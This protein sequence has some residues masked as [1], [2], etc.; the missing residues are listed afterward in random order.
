MRR[1]LRSLVCLA[2]LFAGISSIHARSPN[3]TSGIGAL[4]LQSTTSD[5]N[6]IEDFFS[7]LAS[8]R[9]VGEYA[10]NTAFGKLTVAIAAMTPAQIAMGIPVIDRVLD[11]TVESADQPEFSRHYAKD[12][13]ASLFTFIGRRPDGRELLASQIDR[14]ASMLN[15]PYFNSSAA[16]ALETIYR[17]QPELLVPIFEAPLRAPEVA[18][19]GGIGIAPV[20]AALL[21]YMHL[22]GDEAINEVARYIGRPE[23]AD[24][25]LLYTIKAIDQLQVI[26]DKL[27]PQLVRSLDR[28]NEQIKIQA[29]IGI[30]KSNPSAKDLAR[31]RMEKMANDAAETADVR[32]LAARALVGEITVSGR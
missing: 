20:L 26:P 8:G 9:F 29:L 19:P 23:L 1:H 27:T 15:D 11:N 17:D 24:D 12:Y 31:T 7:A 10:D 25:E 22:R 2:A 3:S 13:A 4:P 28:P 21:L 18:H 5:Q 6:P 32:R 14:L 16:N 30:A